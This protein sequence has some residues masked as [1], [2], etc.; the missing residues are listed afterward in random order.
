M[1]E[2]NKS[3]AP[4]KNTVGQLGDIWIDTV[5]GDRYKLAYIST[6]TTYDGVI[7]DYEWELV[8]NEIPT[9]YAKKT[10]IPTK[11]SSLVNDSGFIN[12]IP[13]EYVTEGELNQKGYLTSNTVL[14]IEVVSELPEVE[15]DGVL[16][17]V[18]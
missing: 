1:A 8:I 14:R 12:E 3:G 9:D 17:I 18:K 7:K 13:T 5:T 15:E 16:Y 11:T 10:D 2:I 6:T 4:D